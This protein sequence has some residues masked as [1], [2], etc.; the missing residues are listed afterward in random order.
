MHL[1]IQSI[2]DTLTTKLI[3]STSSI[4]YVPF[5]FPLCLQGDER[6]TSKDT[7]I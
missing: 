3:Y 2:Y 6:V 4:T 5:N 1:I 7:R